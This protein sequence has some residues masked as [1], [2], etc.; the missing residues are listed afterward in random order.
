M[1]EKLK[2]LEGQRGT[3]HA[4]FSRLGRKNKRVPGKF[5]WYDK[6]FITVLLIDITDTHGTKICDHLW[7]NFTKGFKEAGMNPGERIQFDARSNPYFKGYLGSRDE[8]WT[9]KE[10][11]YCL[12]YPTN[13]QKIDQ[14]SI[15]DLPL[16]NE[17][18]KAN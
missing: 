6:E 10:K 15:Q 8:E 13:I 17:E 1:R 5:G 2:D 16:F 12:V 18:R 7:F 3:F 11:D 9:G 14:Q 4:T